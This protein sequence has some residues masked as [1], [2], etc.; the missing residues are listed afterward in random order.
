MNEYKRPEEVTEEMAEAM[1]A[2]VNRLVSEENHWY[3][4]EQIDERIKE[5]DKKILQIVKI[6]KI[7]LVVVLSILLISI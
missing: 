3:L 1:Q 4:L 5:T 7:I 2:E 6:G